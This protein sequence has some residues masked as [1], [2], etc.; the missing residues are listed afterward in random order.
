MSETYAI[1]VCDMC[2]AHT[3]H[4]VHG[5]CTVCAYRSQAVREHHEAR[6]REARREA[7]PGGDGCSIFSALPLA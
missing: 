5:T 6:L 7:S 3:A 4:T 2:Q 1:R